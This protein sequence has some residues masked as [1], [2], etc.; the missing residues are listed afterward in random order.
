MTAPPESNSHPSGPQHKT[1]DRTYESRYNHSIRQDMS[2]THH[3]QDHFTHHDGRTDMVTR[4][5]DEDTTDSTR[6]PPYYSYFGRH[7][8]AHHNSNRDSET[9]YLD[10]TGRTKTT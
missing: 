4:D 8:D 5:V 6:H 7:C 2:R 10:T 9:H 3:S 1:E